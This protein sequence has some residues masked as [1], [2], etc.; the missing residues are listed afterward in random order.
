MEIKEKIR[1]GKH[2]ALFGTDQGLWVAIL[3]DDEKI[4]RLSAFGKDAPKFGWNPKED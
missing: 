3:D 1:L 2:I 4:I